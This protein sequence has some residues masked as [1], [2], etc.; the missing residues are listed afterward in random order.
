MWELILPILGFLIGII[1]AMTGVGG[2]IFIVPLLTLAYSL[3]PANA[4]GTSLATITFTAIAATLSY[5]RQKIIFYKTG[6]LI[7][8]ATAPGA[9]IGAF[10][11]SVISQTLLGVIFGCFL[12]VVAARMVIE[13]KQDN[14]RK[15]EKDT[16]KEEI[17]EKELLTNKT[18]LVA[19]LVFG[20]FGGIASGLLGIGGGV[21]IVPVMTLILSIPIHIA[22]ATSMLTMIVTSIAGVGQHVALGHINWEFALLLASGSVLGAQVGSFASKKLSAKNLRRVFGLILVIVSIQMILKFI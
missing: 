20:F 8:A 18:H 16:Q 9:I 10:L 21:V 6:L 4:V 1:A 17:K 2:G 15:I 13:N 3:N 5:S 22:V 11:T 14:N 7:A 12:I 19:G